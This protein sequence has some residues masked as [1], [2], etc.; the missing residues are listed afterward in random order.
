[1]NIKTIQFLNQLKNAS[2]FYKE[3][4][5]IPFNKNILCLVKILYKEGYIQ[6]FK[7]IKNLT[8]VKHQQYQ[9]VIQLRYFC[10]KPILNNLKI[11][12]TPSKIKYLSLSDICKLT[13]TKN[14]L[15]FSTSKGILNSI[16][17]KQQLVG[18]T[19][20]FIC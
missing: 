1:M 2:K 20:F 10:D 17:C 9:I 8:P 4:L 16:Q 6:S 3:L 13:V 18:G 14:N 12:S 15:F 5:R 19:L 11:I 7:I